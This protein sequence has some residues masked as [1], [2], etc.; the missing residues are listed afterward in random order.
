MKNNQ[1]L[2]DADI[3]RSQAFIAAVLGPDEIGRLHNQPPEPVDAEPAEPALAPEDKRVAD[4]IANATAWTKEYPKIATEEIAK[5]ATDWLNQLNADHAKIDA[6]RVAERAPL[7]KELQAIQDKYL[8]L[9][10]R[11]AIC[12]DAIEG[13]HTAYKLLAEQRR[14]AAEA[15]A[16]R[17]AAEAQRRADQLTEQA[18]AGG[19]T[20]VAA[21]I[22]AHEA[23]EEA[24]TAR[25][26]AAEVPRR[27]QIRGNLGGR[28]HSLRTV[29]QADIHEIE[30]T[31]QHYKNRR[32]VKELLRSLAIADVRNPR[33]WPDPE[34]R[35]IPGCHT[36]SEQ[37]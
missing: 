6:K 33:L 23:T 4:M 11:I 9:L 21:A 17:V 13:P 14:K 24:E 15:E 12:R 18:K 26:A 31:F 10:T 25:K 32:E 30:K 35:Y 16:A 8:P 22:L 27:T 5:A 29:W 37:V 20:A 2:T 34:D 28:T 3:D 36:Y 1:D 19:P 7:R